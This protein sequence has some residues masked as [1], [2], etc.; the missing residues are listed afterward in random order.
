MIPWALAASSACRSKRA[1]NSDIK[2]LFYNVPQQEVLLE[3]EGIDRYGSSRFMV[4]CGMAPGEFLTLLSRY[5][6]S[7][8][9]QFNGQI[10]NQKEGVSIGSAIA[11]VH[12]DLY[13]AKE[14]RK[15]KPILEDAGV[16]RCFRYVDDYLECIP[17][18]TCTD[19]VIHNVCSV[20][21]S[22]HN[23]LDVTFEFTVDNRLQFLDLE[24][25][26][27][28]EHKCWMYKTRSV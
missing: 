12:C 21:Q 15:T 1:C 2:D 25:S 23:G 6:S 8:F 7:L 16:T 27:G 10:L 3:V 24:I 14:D 11:P 28:L 13:L 22:A 20:F 17:V 18:D 4:K 9:V 19:S 5:L 26:A